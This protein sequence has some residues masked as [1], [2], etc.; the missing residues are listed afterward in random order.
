MLFHQFSLRSLKLHWPFAILLLLIAPLLLLRL[1]ESPSS[2]YDEGLNLN[3][4]QT[5]SATGIYGLTT[6]GGIRLADP[7]IQT[8]PP[9]IALISGVTRL[10]GDSL[11]ATR[12]TIVIISFITLLSLYSLAYRLYG[13]FAALLAVALVVAFPP[14]DTTSTYLMLSRQ[15]LGEVPALLC[16]TL[17]FHLLMSA[18]DR[19]WRW[20]LVGVCWGLAIM[21]KSQVLVVLSASVALWTLYHM[22]R[23]KSDWYRWL[24]ILLVML[25][26][27][28][29]DT[30][31]RTHMAGAA[32]NDN[33]AILREGIW[34]HILPFRW[35]RNLRDDGV[36]MRV[37]ISM[38]TVGGLWVLR[39]RVPR[40]PV[41]PTLPKAQMRVEHF[42]G[43]FVS[44]WMI[45][46]AVV[47]VGWT[48][49]AF[50]GFIFTLVIL[51][52]I[53]TAV[54]NHYR[55][56]LRIPLKLALV[57]VALLAAYGL[58]LPL[59][60]DQQ[61]DD[62]FKMV[63]DL[64]TQVS[65]DAQIVSM[66]WAMDNFVPQHFILPTTHTI[67]V[68]TENAFVRRNPN[69]AFDSAAA[70]PQYV[71]LGSLTLDKTV[72]KSALGISKSEPIY[73]HGIYQLYQVNTQQWPITCRP[74]S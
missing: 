1:S 58:N 3:A 46:Y 25:A 30:M 57:A 38:L 50:V 74:Q 6:A 28:A 60:A 37:G 20:L 65:P 15:F 70:C 47:S 45:W 19:W 10:F 48:R 44:L 61:G 8:G 33:L 35:F 56:S 29:L 71:L 2:W 59:L 68:I 51:S 24:L 69:Y 55:F 49:Y 22:I 42:I 54:L 73:Q 72:L 4:A 41:F 26:I 14:M 13:A 62:F 12:L 5:L 11:F 63:A 18:E 36:L 53:I 16:I 67:N 64:K 32:L 7:A 40:L 31:W 66:E 27:Y 21:L 43:F 52:G 17:G 9:L 34:I 39:Q 23:R